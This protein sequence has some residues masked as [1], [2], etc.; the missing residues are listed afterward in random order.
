MTPLLF[1]PERLAQIVRETIPSTDDMTGC[2]NVVVASVDQN[3]A[4]VVASFRRNNPSWGWELQAA[5]HHDWTGETATAGR[6][7]LKW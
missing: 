5:V 4:Q 1:T 7:I 3:G 2:T 6:V